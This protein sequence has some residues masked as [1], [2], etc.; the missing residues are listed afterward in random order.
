MWQQQIPGACFFS[1]ITLVNH[2]LMAACFRTCFICIWL[3]VNALQIESCRSL[4]GVFAVVWMFCLHVCLHTMGISGAWRGQKM[5][6]DLLN[7]SYRW[8]WASITVLGIRSWC[9][10]RVANILNHWAIYPVSE[11]KMSKKPC[12]R[13]PQ[14][15]QPCSRAPQERQLYSRVSQERKIPALGYQRIDHPCSRV[16]KDRPSLL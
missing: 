16:P 7:W 10:A 11:W 2:T 14:D 8:L 6:S 5:A 9:S 13:V 1:F 3:P 15:R 12:S 4:V